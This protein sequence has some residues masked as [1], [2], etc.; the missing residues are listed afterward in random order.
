MLT[1][2]EIKHFALVVILGILVATVILGAYGAIADRTLDHLAFGI[3]FMPLVFVPFVIGVTLFAALQ[4]R[5]T[6]TGSQLSVTNRLV[7][8]ALVGA[9]VYIGAI[10]VFYLFDVYH[11]GMT[12]KLTWDAFFEEFTRQGFHRWVIPCVLGAFIAD[13]MLRLRKSK[14][15]VNPQDR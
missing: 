5:L 12:G 6:M 15:S 13:H 3:L 11:F 2:F 1:R 10:V 7:L 14:A 8:W 4:R 9:F